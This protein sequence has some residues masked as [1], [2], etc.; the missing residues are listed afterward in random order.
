[1]AAKAVPRFSYKCKPEVGDSIA[2]SEHLLDTDK[3]V[4][5]VV[6]VQNY[7]NIPTKVTAELAA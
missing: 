3:G 4:R 2:A 7:G 6:H 5:L 1:M